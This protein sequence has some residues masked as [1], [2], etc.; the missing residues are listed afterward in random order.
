MSREDDA[1]AAELR[2]YEE[3]RRSAFLDGLP[4]EE[5]S[6]WE[7]GIES[8]VLSARKAQQIAAGVS[9]PGSP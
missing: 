9:A 6:A 1:Y 2:W 8:A 7:W 5:R 4:A 3:V